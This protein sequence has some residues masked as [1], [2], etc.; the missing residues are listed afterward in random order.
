MGGKP[1]SLRPHSRV[2]SPARQVPLFVCLVGWLVF[3]FC[4]GLFFTFIFIFLQVKDEFKDIS[5]YFSK[6][7]WAEMGE[8]EKI[9][10]RNMKRNYK[11]LISIGNKKSWVE[12]A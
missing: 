11:T 5:I 8:W 10:Y 9:R 12:P 4:F 7:E 6:E 1:W 3:L 2:P